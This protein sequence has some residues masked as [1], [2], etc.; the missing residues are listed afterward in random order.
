M[1]NLGFAVEWGALR[2]HCAAGAMLVLAI[3]G[4]AAPG[5]APDAPLLQRMGGLPVLQAVVGDTIDTVVADPRTRRSFE[6]IKLPALKANLVTH[7]C[8]LAGGSCR[9]E[10]ETMAKAHRGLKISDAEFDLMVAALRAAL[11]RRVG[12]REKNEM[13]RLLAP[14]KRDIVGA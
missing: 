11:D 3:A 12:A 7:L 9:Y 13:L 14:M 5:A 4:C 1:K 8:S 10:G 6:G 2:R